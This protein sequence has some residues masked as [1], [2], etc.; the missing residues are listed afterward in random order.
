M[1]YRTDLVGAATDRSDG[2]RAG[3]RAGAED[4]L[5][6]PIPPALNPPVAYHI[7]LLDDAPQPAEARGFL[8]FLAS[9]AGRAVLVKHGFLA[10]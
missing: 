6:I 5:A 2:T 4:L 7:A 8:E 9:P 3:P 10:P 1:V